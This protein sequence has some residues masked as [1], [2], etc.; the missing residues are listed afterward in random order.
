MLRSLHIP[1]RIVTGFRGGE[2]NDLTSQYVVRASDAHS[3]VEA[4]FSGYGWI[5]F[6][7]TPAGGA[8]TRNVWSR[9]QLYIDAAASFWRE[10]IINYDVG[11]QR[12][13]GKQAVNSG[14]QFVDDVR[15]WIVHLHGTLLDSA[16]RAHG[17]F[18]SF[19]IRWLSRF[20]G[21]TV[22][23]I[24]LLNLRRLIVAVHNRRLRKHPERAPRESAALW[25]GRMVGRMA[26]RGWHKSPSQ[27]PLAFVAAIQE[28]ELQ[29]KVASFT[30]AYESA[31]FGNSVDDAQNL[32]A[33]FKE[34]TAAEMGDSE[35]VSTAG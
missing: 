11:H 31:R 19:P 12:T 3:W 15:Q 6:D 8:P 16:R 1:S 33:L 21:L 25:Y 35:K 27:T 9:M 24:S 30:R 5:S 34:I 32:P 22:V 20:I 2:F 29:K 7:P 14:R 23:V 18:T 4:Y 26:R 17:R 13:L 10:W 28:A